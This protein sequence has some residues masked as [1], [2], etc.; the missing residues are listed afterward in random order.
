MN[1]FEKVVNEIKEQDR[2][3]CEEVMKALVETEKTKV[4]VRR[5][6]MRAYGRRFQDFSVRSI[7][8]AL[9]DHYPTL[10]MNKHATVVAMSRMLGK[11]KLTNGKLLSAEYR[12]KLGD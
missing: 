8:R 10:F 3:D 1:E 12:I 7:A 4:E 9:T 2:N 6:I 11:W 5:K